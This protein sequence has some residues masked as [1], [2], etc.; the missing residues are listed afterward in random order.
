MN[1]NNDKVLC[2]KVFFAWNDEIVW[3]PICDIVHKEKLDQKIVIRLAFAVIQ[4]KPL[5]KT[6]VIG[7]SGLEVWKGKSGEFMVRL[8]GNG[9]MKICLHISFHFQL[10]VHQ[11]IQ[12][13]YSW[14]VCY[15]V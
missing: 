15:I 8:M 2:I 14:N 10:Q 5:S 13:Q 12:S 4:Q 1:W 6:R 11:S 3:T 7:K 9:V